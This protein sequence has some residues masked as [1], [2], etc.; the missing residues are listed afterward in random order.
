MI[1][2]H[3]GKRYRVE[4]TYM[5]GKFKVWDVFT[6]KGR[7]LGTFEHDGDESPKG[8]ESWMAEIIKIVKY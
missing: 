2:R 5:H 7:H 3:Y 8:K 1:I 6:V 4:N